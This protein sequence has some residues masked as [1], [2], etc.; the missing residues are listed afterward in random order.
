MRLVT[1]IFLQVFAGFLILSQVLFF[2]LLNETKNENLLDVY[3]YE[4]ETFKKKASSFFEKLYDYELENEEVQIQDIVAGNA[5]HSVFGLEAVLYREGREIYNETPYIFDSEKIL[6]GTEG[7]AE[8]TEFGERV[9]ISHLLI[10]EVDGKRLMFLY[11]DGKETERSF[12]SYTMEYQ[13]IWYKD[14]TDIFERT[15]RLARNG[16][17]FTAGMLI[18]M[19]SLFLYFLRRTM[20]PLIKL[21]TAAAAIA[22]GDY[23]SRVPAGRKDEIGQL[24]ESFNL[25]A[26]QIETHVEQLTQTNEAQKQLIAGLAHE[27]KTPMTAI[28]GYSDTLLNLQLKE[29]QKQKALRYIG[30]ECRRLSRLSAK[31]MELTGLYQT[32]EK[33]VQMETVRIAELLQ[34]LTDLT[35]YRLQ[36]KQ[37]RMQ[38]EWEPEYLE[39]KMDRDLMLSLLMNLVDNAC[40]ASEVGGKLLVRAD[41]EGISVQ[42]YGKGIPEEEISRVT[43]A[44]YMVDK[45]RARSQGSVG[46]GLALCKRIAEIHGGK[47]EI[48]SEVGKGTRVLVRFEE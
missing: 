18:V 24:A 1:K 5:F 40:K 10:A 3:A 21:K 30:S 8:Y 34:Q 4:E 29:E 46:L 25:M 9:D 45:S 13:I 11:C 48:E 17:I 36:E 47:L 42:D 15:G 14:V 37:I 35:T 22:A 39:K 43:E 16:L 38:T 33:A 28:I 12:G 7:K 6:N 2:Y 19:G 44:F 23:E 41:E 26:G 20:R 32:G 31:M 27:L